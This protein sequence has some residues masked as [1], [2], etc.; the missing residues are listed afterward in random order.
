MQARV[1]EDGMGEDCSCVEDDGERAKRTWLGWSKRWTGGNK[2]RGSAWTGSL[3]TRAEG[4]ELRHS[5]M[6]RIIQYCS[7]SLVKASCFDIK[8]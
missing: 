2:Q 1:K 4:R 7:C 3:Q 6:I 8:S 5:D